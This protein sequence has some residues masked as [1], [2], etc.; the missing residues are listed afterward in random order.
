MMTNMSPMT[1]PDGHLTKMFLLACN[2]N[3][4]FV[5]K[6]P[7]LIKRDKK[8]TSYTIPTIVPT[9]QRYIWTLLQAKTC[10]MCTFYEKGLLVVD[11]HETIGT[12]VAVASKWVPD[13]LLPG[14]L[15]DRDVIVLHPA[16][17]MWVIDVSPVVASISLAFMDQHC[18]KP[19]W[20]LGQHKGDLNTD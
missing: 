17:L 18:V 2:C 4:L 20:N 8:P 11:I 14:R 9:N 10:S 6:M 12:G 16:T 15:G 7:K 13:Q 3:Q 5:R 1:E 19:V